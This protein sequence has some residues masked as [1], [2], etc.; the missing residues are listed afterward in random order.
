[1]VSVWSQARGSVLLH[2]PLWAF[3]GHWDLVPHQGWLE[4]LPLFIFQLPRSRCVCPP[5]S[6]MC[7]PG[8][9]SVKF[10]KLRCIPAVSKTLPATADQ[11]GRTL[12]VLQK[13]TN[14]ICGLR[15]AVKGLKKGFRGTEEEID[16]SIGNGTLSVVGAV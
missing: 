12:L 2:L 4:G 7:V 10:H 15:K 6:L 16:F 8:P 5:H 11:S 9:L 14:R 13:L 1:M 3:C